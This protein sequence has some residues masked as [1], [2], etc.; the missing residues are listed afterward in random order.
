MIKFLEG[1]DEKCVA[2]GP[3]WLSMFTMLVTWG[4]ALMEGWIKEVVPRNKVDNILNM[5]KL[6]SSLSSLTAVC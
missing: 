1:L 4:R 3:I 5:P 2:K 6:E